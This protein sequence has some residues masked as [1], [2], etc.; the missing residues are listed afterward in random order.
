MDDSIEK[1]YLKLSVLVNPREYAE[2]CMDA[3]VNLELQKRGLATTFY[4]QVALAGLR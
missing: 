4:H 2:M 3:I 1:K